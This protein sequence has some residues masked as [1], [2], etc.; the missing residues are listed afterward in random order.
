MEAVNQQQEPFITALEALWAMELRILQA[1][2]DLIDKVH[3]TGLKNILRMHYAESANQTS[4]LRG[5]A[6]QL[7]VDL[8]LSVRGDFE[9]VITVPDVSSPEGDAMI[10]TLCKIIEEY[11]IEKYTD[12]VE[13]ASRAE[14]EGILKTLHVILNEEKLAKVKLNFAEKNI[15]Q[16]GVEKEHVY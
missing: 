14:W 16:L 3:N 11:E 6:K 2:P 9:P 12:A 10:I 5:I 8:Q 15:R 1:M 7:D 13:L 4:M